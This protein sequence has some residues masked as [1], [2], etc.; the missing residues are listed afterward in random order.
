MAR[1]TKKNKTQKNTKLILTIY[2]VLLVVIIIFLVF[3]FKPKPRLY[4]SSC[5][6]LDF[7]CSNFTISSSSINFTLENAFNDDITYLKLE[8]LDQQPEGC[9]LQTITL[10]WNKGEKR[11][12]T[13]DCGE[14]GID[15]Q[16]VW[17]RFNITYTSGGVNKSAVGS[18]SSVPVE[19]E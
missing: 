3:A 4:A 19:I 18:V 7:S 11:T 15:K 1:R 2:G 12:F 9:I 17:L 14:K 10:P 16:P 6:V 5:L 13:F 8:L